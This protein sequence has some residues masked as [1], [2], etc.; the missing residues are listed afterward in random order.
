MLGESDAGVVWYSEAPFQQMIGNPIAMVEIPPE[1]N[2]NGIYQAG[3]FKDAPHAEA[4]RAFAKFL[5]SDKAQAIFSKYG[6]SG[7]PQEVKH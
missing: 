3:I 7:P 2:M 5:L 6:F 1:Q 4:A